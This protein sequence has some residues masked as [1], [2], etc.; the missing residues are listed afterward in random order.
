MRH[1]LL[2]LLLAA[3][4]LHPLAWPSRAAAQPAGGTGI[5][6]SPE[7]VGAASG[8]T[9]FGLELYRSLAPRDGNIFI[10]PVSVAGVL[11]MAYAGAAGD[12]AEAF[13][14][15]LGIPYRG[16]ALLKSWKGLLDSLDAASGDGSELSL[17]GS[18]WPD[19]AAKLRRGYVRSVERTFGAKVLPQD[20]AGGGD[21]PRLAINE[22]AA[23]ETRDRVRDLVPMPL[24]PDTRLVLA[25]AVYFKGGWREPFDRAETSEGRFRA[26][27]GSVAGPYKPP[28]GPGGESVVDQ[29]ERPEYSNL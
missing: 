25:N 24:P 28:P 10:S 9:A 11:A 29:G 17:A 22:W 14:G 19:S 6:I 23:R 5:E 7:A 8:A 2:T 1:M 4:A 3:A 12:T 27:S 20:F 26:P 18:V 15:A 21:A 16:E 13:E